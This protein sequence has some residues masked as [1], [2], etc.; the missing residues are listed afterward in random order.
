[1]NPDCKGPGGFHRAGRNIKIELEGRSMGLC[2]D[3]IRLLFDTGRDDGDPLFLG[4][5]KEGNH[6]TEEEGGGCGREGDRHEIY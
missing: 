1:M 5:G 2:V 4:G 6:E 3:D